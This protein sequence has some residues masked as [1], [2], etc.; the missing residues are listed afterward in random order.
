[1][2]TNLLRSDAQHRAELISGVHYDIALDITGTDT[3]T[4]RS[5]VTFESKEGETFFDLV[6]DSFEATLDG[7]LIDGRTLP[8]T[9]FFNDMS[10]T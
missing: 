6:A 5:T 1:M 4:A 2:K 3:F 9:I 8:L 10:L 7:T